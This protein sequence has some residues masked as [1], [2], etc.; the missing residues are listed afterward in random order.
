MSGKSS[1]FKTILENI[2]LVRG[3]IARPAGLVDIFQD[4]G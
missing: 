4:P 2:P 1:P 3:S